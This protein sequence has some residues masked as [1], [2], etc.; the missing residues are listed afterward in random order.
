MTFSALRGVFAVILASAIC[1][2]PNTSYA[3]SQPCLRGVNVAG[4]EFGDLPGRYG[5]DYAYPTRET[6]ASLAMMGITAIRLPFR[7][8]RLQP[9]LNAPLDPNELARLDM[10]VTAAKAAGLTTILDLHNFAYFNQKRL[11]SPEVGMN[12]F[13]DFWGRLAKHYRSTREVAFGLMNE[14]Y[15]L[16]ARTWL[17]GANAAIASIRAAQAR[18]LILVPGTAYS[19]A[20]SWTADL[21]VGNNGT[22]M[23]GIA[24]PLDNFA[25]EFHQYLDSDYSGRAASCE[26][27]AAALASFKNVDRWLT[28]HRKRGFVGEIAASDRAECRTALAN[29]LDYL[30]TNPKRWIGWTIWAA[31]ERWPASYP[32]NLQ[33]A[34]PTPPVLKLLADRAKTKACT[35]SNR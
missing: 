29:I 16:P 17:I 4:A 19:G 30:D 6:I 21:P 8:E 24:D 2:L 33:P 3:T 14:P 27:G 26:N 15:D 9:K 25:F 20:H 28:D 1:V 10:T 22:T 7:W 18:Q 32:F 11:D 35:R 5:Y 23:L 12:S 13:A 34:S 31:G